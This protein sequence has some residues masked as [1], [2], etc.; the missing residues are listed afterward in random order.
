[1]TDYVLTIL[2]FLEITVA[3]LIT[4]VVLMQRSKSG[5]GLGA[6]A[7]GATEEVFGSGA[8]NV[9]SKITVVLATFFLLNT[10]SISVLQG[11][12]LKKKNTS[13]VESLVSEEDGLRIDPVLD[14]D[15]S[16]TEIPENEK[17][18]EDPS[19]AAPQNGSN[20]DEQ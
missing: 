6:L 5:G 7:G 3:V 20:Q 15:T 16:N 14:T 13:V 19:K 17:S 11:N 9:L 10:L 1:M 18:S 8:S 12:A 2:N 4:L